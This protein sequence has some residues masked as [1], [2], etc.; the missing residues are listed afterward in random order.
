VKNGPTR[1]LSDLHYGDRASRLHEPRALLPLLDGASSIVLNGDSVDT[2]C[3]PDPEATAAACRAMRDFFTHN[4]PP[5]TWLTGNHDP[6]ISG[7][8]YL[9]LNGRQVLVTHGDVLFENLVPWGRDAAALSRQISVELARLPPDQKGRLTG[10]FTAIRAAAASIPQRHQTER[11]LA[12]YL[13][14]LFADTLWPPT[15][16]L[17][18]LKAWRET[19]E[20]AECFLKQ[21]SLPARVV[22]TGHTHRLGITRSRGGVMIVN[23]GSL[24]PP[25][26][27]GVADLYSDHLILRSVTRRSGAFHLGATIGEIS[28][29]SIPEPQTLGL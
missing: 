2:R 10:K 23:T 25:G 29:A 5:T 14:S 13:V 11:N 18:V 4:A 27:G 9:E 12:K 26:Q 7:H 1:I 21:Y 16:I 28:L 19:P 15:R 22:V 8:H 20:R 24:C 3:G 17:F 6:D